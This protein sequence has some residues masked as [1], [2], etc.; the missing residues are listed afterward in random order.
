MAQTVLRPVN[1]LQAKFLN[2]I[3]VYHSDRVH[4]GY[5]SVIMPEPK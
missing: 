1:C 4:A 2:W 5:R 3:L